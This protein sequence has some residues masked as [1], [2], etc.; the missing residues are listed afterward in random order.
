[1]YNLNGNNIPASFKRMLKKNNT[2]HNYSTRQAN[3]V[4]IP[5]ARTIFISRTFMLTGPKFANSLDQLLK[6]A[7]SLN[8]FEVS[9]EDIVQKNIKLWLSKCNESRRGSRGGGGAQSPPKKLAQAPPPQIL[10]I[11]GWGLNPPKKNLLIIQLTNWILWNG[12]FYY[13]DVIKMTITR[14]KGEGR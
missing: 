8:S 7:C 13:R 10:T 2:V 3:D 5:K 1:M 6:E 14:A 11:I 4:H 9:S 12:K